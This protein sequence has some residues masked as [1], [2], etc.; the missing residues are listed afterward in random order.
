MIAIRARHAFDGVEVS[1]DGAVVLVEGQ[2][3]A[4]VESRQF[5]PPTGTEIIDS[6]GTVLP[7]LVN[8]HVHL[9][10]DG[11]DGALERLPELS[12]EE[13]D[14]IIERALAIQLASGVTTVRDLGD[15]EWA[16]VE[17]RDQARSAEPHIVA[18]GPPITSVGGHCW[19]MGGEAAGVD[20]LRAAVRE[21]AERRVDVVKIMASGGAMTPGTDIGECQFTLDELR[22]VVDE[23]H[24][25][26]LPVTAHAHALSAVERAIDAGV[27]GIEHCTCIT[28]D[29]AD[30]S[31]ALWKRL[32][33]AQIVVCP[34]LGR[35]P[36]VSPP[37]RVLEMLASWGMTFEQRYS[38]VAAA[39][40]AGVRLISGDDGGITSG[41]R[42]GVFAEALLSLH[43]G[44]VSVSD[45]LASGTSAAA[46]GCGVGDRKGRL[47]AGYDAD[48][49]VVDGDA[50]ADLTALRSV[51]AVFL[52]GE[53]AALA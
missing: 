39:H 3:V 1:P 9:C 45:A 7:G 18:S 4:G 53:R 29:G 52:R 11:R 15:P 36:G 30:F 37:P 49:L 48:I 14:V 5:E 32:I 19:M 17:R 2:R 42:H 46:D 38:T 41:K 50:T 6:K 34:T 51:S 16:V 22:A 21:R 25:L 27:D 44:G 43:W 20:A 26:G 28:A 33:E 47:R 8:T 40:A 31:P 10:G 24:G 23:S 13:V 12:R 35:D